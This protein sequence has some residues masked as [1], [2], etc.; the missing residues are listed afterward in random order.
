MT[1]GFSSKAIRTQAERSQFREHAVPIYATSSYLF[2]SAEDARAHF[3]GEI[4]GPIYSR[5]SNP[6]TDEFVDK[7]AG[8]EG[9]ET[10]VATASGMA[11]VYALFAGSLSAGDHLV[12]S[13]YVFGSTH[14]LITRI[15]PRFGIS[16]SYV[17]GSDPHAWKAAATNATKLFY[18][19]TPSN[20][21]LEVID[22]AAVAGAARELEIPL[23]VDNCFA[24]PA[25]QRPLE[26]GASLVAHSATKFIDGQGRT[27]GGAVLGSEELI[28]PIRFFAR[29]TGPALSPFNAWILSKSLETLSLRMERH[30]ASALALAK[31][32]EERSEVSR[33]LYPG[34]PSHP[35]HDIARKQM[36]SGGGLV[37]FELSAGLDG[38]RRFLDSLMM[39]SRSANLGDSRSIATHPASTT[40]SK[41]SKE[42]RLAAGVT[43]GLIRI[44]VGLEDEADIITDVE[45]GLSGAI[46]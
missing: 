13:R 25:I 7:L 28:E 37:S 6:N 35:G 45:G 46:R 21:R 22:I 34:L 27:M 26:L 23:A 24:T 2:D 4:D 30:S 14:Q 32:L 18:L 44:S 39:I 3:A 9:A 11:A 12:S 33:V 38:G 16:H 17:D 43:P 40:H 19:E 36:H 42:E 41:L 8:M 5:Y 20:P 29:H 15:L 31:Y 10:G 1:R